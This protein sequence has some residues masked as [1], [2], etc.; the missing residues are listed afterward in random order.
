MENSL[1]KLVKNFCFENAKK[2]LEISAFD[3]SEKI[4]LRFRIVGESLLKAFTLHLSALNSV[5]ILKSSSFSSL[6][7]GFF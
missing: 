6:S 1:L 4:F 7:S 3:F 5:T 2:S